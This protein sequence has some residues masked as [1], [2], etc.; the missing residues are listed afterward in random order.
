MDKSTNFQLK[1]WTTDA[2]AALAA[3]KAAGV[4]VIYPDKTLFKAQVAIMLQSYRH[5]LIYDLLRC[6]DE[7]H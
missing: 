5:Q 4:E 2:E 6:I 7:V 1:L 3:V